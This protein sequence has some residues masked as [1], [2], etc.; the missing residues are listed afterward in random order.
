MADQLRLVEQLHH[1]RIEADRHRCI[2]LQHAHRPPR[3]EPPGLARAVSVPGPLCACACAASG[4]PRSRSADACRAPPPRPRTH[5][6]AP[7]GRARAKARVPAGPARVGRSRRPAHGAAPWRFGRWCRP[8]AL[9]DRTGRVDEATRYTAGAPEDPPAGPVRAHEDRH[10]P[11]HRQH[12]CLRQGQG[13]GAQRAERGGD[14]RRR[15]SP[16]GG[17]KRPAR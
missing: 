4:R 1:R 15:Q 5:P 3:G 7:T 6:P 11:R 9:T 17:G 14:Q 2:G 12:P 8:Q 13:R 16:R 10:R